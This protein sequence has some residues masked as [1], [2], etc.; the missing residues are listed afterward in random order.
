VPDDSLIVHEHR[1]VRFEQQDLLVKALILE[2]KIEYLE[3]DLE[4]TE[5]IS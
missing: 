5:A 2:M 1:L 4:R 3:R